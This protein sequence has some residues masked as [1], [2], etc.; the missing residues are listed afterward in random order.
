MIQKRVHMSL[1]V[2]NPETFRESLTIKSLKLRFVKHV[3]GVH[4]S[5]KPEEPV[6]SKG[7]V[8][9]SMIAFN[10]LLELFPRGSR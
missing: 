1:M 2:S 9:I 8:K 3:N 7:P 4:P 10:S 6:L 5:Y